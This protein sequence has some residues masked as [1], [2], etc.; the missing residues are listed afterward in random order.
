MFDDLKMAWDLWAIWRQIKGGNMDEAQIVQLVVLLIPVIT[1]LITVGIKKILPKIPKL[2][3]IILQPLL[4][5]IL[6]ALG[7]VDP[8][9]GA[10]L[11]VA[12]IGVREGVD[13]TKKTVARRKVKGG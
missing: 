8:A 5:A 4:G 12:G 1:P 11:G 10:G 7:G 3:V 2:V 6:G 9:F 13:Q